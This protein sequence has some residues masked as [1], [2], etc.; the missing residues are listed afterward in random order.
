[1]K[2]KHK[3]ED[4]LEVVQARVYET[5]VAMGRVTRNALLVQHVRPRHDYIKNKAL[6]IQSL[7]QLVKL[8]LVIH[9]KKALYVA[10]LNASTHEKDEYAD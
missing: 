4:S 5:V 3:P 2:P 6:V 8:G 9:V 1:M 10:T 7:K